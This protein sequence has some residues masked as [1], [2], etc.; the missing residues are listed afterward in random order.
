TFWRDGFALWNPI[1]PVIHWVSPHRVP[2]QGGRLTIAGRYFGWNPAWGRVMLDN[3]PLRVLEWTDGKIV[4]ELPP[5]VRAGALQV[6]V[7]GVPTNRFRLERAFDLRR[8]AAAPHDRQIKGYTAGASVSGGFAELRAADNT[9]LI[10]KAR[11]DNGNLVLYLL[12]RG[13]DKERVQGDLRIVYRRQGQ[14]IPSGVIEQ[15]ELYNFSTGSYPYGVFNTLLQTPVP[16]GAYQES[17]LSVSNPAQY[18]SYEGDL[19]VRIVISGAGANGRLLI[20]QLLFEW[21]E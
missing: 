18:I 4:A 6:I 17:V 16:S 19:F 1:A 13:L 14:N 9:P 7:R 10:A 21:V 12:V 8:R 5:G 3:R 15:L 11:D 20:D 2:V